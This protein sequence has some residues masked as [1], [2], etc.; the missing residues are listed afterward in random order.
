MSIHLTVKHLRRIAR[1]DS[2]FVA[3]VLLLAI[4]TGSCGRSENSEEPGGRPGAVNSAA[5][6]IDPATA[7]TVTGT[8]QFDGALPQMKSINMASVPSCAKLHSSP[9]M[10]QDVVPGNNG[11][12]QNVAVYLKGDFSQYSFPPAIAPVQIDQSGCVY[13][14]HVVAIMTG[15]PL[16]VTNSD[17]TTDNVNAIS[18]YRQGWNQTL[19]PGSAPIERTFAREEIPIAVKCNI[20]PWM[21]FYVAVLRHPYFQVTGNDGSFLLKNVPPGS[22]TL[23]AVSIRQW[24]ANNLYC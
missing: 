8:V 3:G 20:H 6:P 13:S 17:A 12:L 9:Q 4:F 2:L 5:K 19:A 21:K 24:F 18:T 23:T 14:P 22:Y 7:G 1:L 16:Q 11:R 10:V 15:E